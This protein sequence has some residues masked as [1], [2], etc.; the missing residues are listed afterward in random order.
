M[1]YYITKKVHPWLYT[2]Y[3]PIGVY[4]YLIA[5]KNSA[6]IYDTCHGIAPLHEAIANVCSLPY[7]VVLSHGHWDH[8][9]GA[10]QFNEVWLHPG[11]NELCLRHFSKSTR[12]SIVD[13]YGKQIK[14]EFAYDFDDAK[15]IN[16]TKEA[17]L[18]PLSHGQIFD[19]GGITVEIV[20]MEGHTAGS[21]G[22][23]I[24]EHK[25]LLNGDAAN[26][27]CW[28]FLEDSLHMSVYINMLK[29][30]SKLD[31]NNFIMSHSETIY[32]KSE[33]EKYIAVAENIDINKSEPYSYK[34]D[35]LGGYFYEENG[36]GIVFDPKRA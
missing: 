1:S 13:F 28:M 33:F 8:T 27:H 17:K 34:F 19:L 5:G 3:D 10:Y 20:P 11:D 30:V 16:N 12:S 29:Q 6:L 18:K 21:V 36:V 32:P 14:E 23:L 24:K 26:G 7:E 25:L 15:Y 4:S 35:Q 9:G 22:V 31:F 2:I